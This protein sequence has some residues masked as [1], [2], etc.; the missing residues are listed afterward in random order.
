MLP[1]RE[2]SETDGDHGEKQVTKRL[3]KQVRNAS[4]PP[5]GRSRAPNAVS[6]LTITKTA[7]RTA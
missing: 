3:G 5:S 1:D 7:P 6:A 2:A 4:L